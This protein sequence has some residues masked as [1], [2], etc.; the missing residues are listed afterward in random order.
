[1]AN[2]NEGTI[3][4][5]QG[6]NQYITGLFGGYAID[7][8]MTH[9][10]IDTDNL[11]HRLARQLIQVG[12]NGL[13]LSI[14]L[15]FLHG[16]T[17]L[18]NYRDFTGGYMLAVGL[19]QSQPTFMKNGKELATGAHLFLREMM[20]TKDQPVDESSSLLKAN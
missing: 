11:Y 10:P 6:S 17:P 12:L 5:I 3:A 16:T 20:H 8:L 2:L 13:A 4:I 14:M 1:M 15:K 19:I 7:L 18:S 9:V